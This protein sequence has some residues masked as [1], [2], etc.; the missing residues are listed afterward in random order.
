MTHVLSFAVR[1]LS[2]FS[3][4]SYCNFPGKCNAAS[5]EV[6][7]Q[8]GPTHTR[9][10]ES[11]KIDHRRHLM[12]R[13]YWGHILLTPCGASFWWH[14]WWRFATAFLL[15]LV[16]PNRR[17]SANGML[18]AIGWSEP[19]GTTN[20]GLL[21][22][23]LF[24]QILYDFPIFICRKTFELASPQSDLNDHDYVLWVMYNPSHGTITL[25]PRF[26]R[27]RPPGVLARV[28]RISKGFSVFIISLVFPWPTSDYVFRGT[29][30]NPCKH[31]P[32]LL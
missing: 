10:V 27:Q 21:S 9:I 30:K 11:M 4:I 16:N 15:K 6:L 7:R 18:W 2:L 22:V 31:H 5:D 12:L 24:R 8:P 13:R 17:N 26:S 20:T 1:G 32:F 23:Q 14:P 25:T 28:R 19:R 3:Q 29:L